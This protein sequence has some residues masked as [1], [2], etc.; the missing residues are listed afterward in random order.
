MSVQNQ[1]LGQTRTLT[2]ANRLEA[3][4][5]ALAAFVVGGT[6]VYAMG[7]SHPTFLHNAAHDWRHSMNFPCH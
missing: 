4:K 2:S 6:L 5:A 7:F 3:L 1:T